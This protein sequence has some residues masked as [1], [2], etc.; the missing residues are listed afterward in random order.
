MKLNCN[1]VCVYAKVLNIEK[2]I[3]CNL[4]NKREYFVPD[5]TPYVCCFVLF[6]KVVLL[7]DIIKDIV[8]EIEL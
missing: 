4:D 7:K 2:Q 6:F 3:R 1:D 5:L 8:Y